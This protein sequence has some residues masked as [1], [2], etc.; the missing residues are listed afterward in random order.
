M[1]ECCEEEE[2]EEK[3]EEEGEDWSWKGT[4][5]S[6]SSHPTFVCMVTD[7]V[8]S[9]QDMHVIVATPFLVQLPCSLSVLADGTLAN[10]YR[11]S[12]ISNYLV[13]IKIELGWVALLSA[14]LICSE[15]VP[16]IL[17]LIIHPQQYSF[18]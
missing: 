5:L 9:S 18:H 15:N 2:E 7:K 11:Q 1:N 6:K 3:E 17:S 13:L 12:I 16:M 4:F 14:I 8:W 10:C